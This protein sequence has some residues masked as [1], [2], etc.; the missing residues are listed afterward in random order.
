MD[1]FN[2]PKLKDSFSGKFTWI[3]DTGVTHHFTKSFLLLHNVWKIN[4]CLVGLWDGSMVDATYEGDVLLPEI[5]KLVNVLFVPT[6][7][8]N[9]I[10]VP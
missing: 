9:L 7:D 4:S 1:L 8:C 2:F 3:I 10:Y 5:L 6:L